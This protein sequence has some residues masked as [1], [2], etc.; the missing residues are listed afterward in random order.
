MRRAAVTLVIVLLPMS[1]CIDSSRVNRTCAWVEE[2][3]QRLDVS[4]WADRQ[5]LRVDAQLA[6]EL[7]VRLADVRFRNLANL[8]DPIQRA[9][10]SAMIDTI[11]N[12]HGVARTR[13]LEALDYRLWWADLLVV[14]LPLAVLVAFGMDQITRRIRRSFDPED[15]WFALASVTSFVPV[16]AL[17]GLLAGQLWA[18]EAEGL[19]LRNEHIAFR[20]SHIPI[21]RHGWIAYF[22]LLALAIVVAI[23]RARVTHLQRDVPQWGLAS[24]AGVAGSRPAPATFEKSV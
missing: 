24:N 23:G 17:L 2:S 16:V 5:H 7:G 13:V 14:Y 6:G 9:C 15:R 12:R 1:G 3:T 19:F 20:A 8:G 11:A 4:Q 18:F 21:T 22:A 10:T